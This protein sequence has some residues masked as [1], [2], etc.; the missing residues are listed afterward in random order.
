[1]EEPEGLLVPFI[2]ESCVMEG[3]TDKE[4]METSTLSEFVT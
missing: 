2:S 3:I 4:K 1:M